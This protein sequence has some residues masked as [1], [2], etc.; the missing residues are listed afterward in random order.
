M[1]ADVYAVAR[2]IPRNSL[3]ECIGNGADRQIGRALVKQHVN[4]LAVD[5]GRDNLLVVHIDLNTG[6][7][8]QLF[9]PAFGG[10]FAR[11]LAAQNGRLRVGDG[12]Q[13]GKCDFRCGS[14][15]IIRVTSIFS[16]VV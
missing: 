1:T 2:A 13:L 10:V 4:R 9:C 8:G 11:S 12:F 5:V 14:Q 16:P 3:I 7:N 6:L 15:V